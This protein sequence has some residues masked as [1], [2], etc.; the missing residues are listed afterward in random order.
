MPGL[1]EQL[2]DLQ[3]RLWAEA[4]RSLLVVLQAMDAGGKDGTIKHVFSGVN[5]QG[6][7]VTSFKEPSHVELAHDFLWRVH[8]AVPRG[9]G[10]RDLQSFALRRRAHRSRAQ[11]RSRPRVEGALRPHQFV[12]G[13]ARP[14]RHNGDQ[15]VPS[16]LEGRATQAFRRAARA[17]RRSVGSSGPR[18]SRSGSAGTSTSGAYEDAIGKTSTAGA[19]WYVIPANHKWYRNWAVSSIL[20]DTLRRLDPQYPDPQV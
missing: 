11:A 15:A 10:D 19:P 8:Q 18:I 7:R 6:T 4:S 5:P 9:G 13:D 16:H 12:R 14:R 1:Q 17:S 20:V 2:A 3:V